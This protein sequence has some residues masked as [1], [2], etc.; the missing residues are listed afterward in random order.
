MALNNVP[1]TGQT[2]GQTRDQISGNFSVINAAF[3][4]DHVEYNIGG[5]GFHKQVTFPVQSGGSVPPVP[6]NNT[7]VMYMTLDNLTPPNG[8]NTGINQ[9]FIKRDTDSATS[10]GTPIT[11]QVYDNGTTSGWSMLPSG[12]IVKWGQFSSAGN[13]ATPVNL[14]GPAYTG[15]GTYSVTISP[16]S[17][18]T[19]AATYAI[20]YPSNNQ[21]TFFTPQ[22]FSAVVFRYIAIGI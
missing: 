9:L 21:F 22:T 10:L 13:I 3:L 6:T 20:T 2:L 12:V 11:A 17:V 7:F 15:T 19:P 5:Q 1:Q 14:L 8:T 16:M 18:I 4:V